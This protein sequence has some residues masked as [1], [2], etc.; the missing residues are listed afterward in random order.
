MSKADVLLVTD[1]V[2]HVKDLSNA[3]KFDHDKAKKILDVLSM[4]P[5]DLSKSNPEHLFMS[6][7][8]WT[9]PLI[10]IG[11]QYLGCC[12][13]M[14]FSHIHS[15]MLELSSKANCKEKFEEHKASYLEQ[16]VVEIL[17]QKFPT[18]QIWE[19]LKW[20]ID[21]TEYETDVLLQIDQ[22]IFIVEAKSA[23]ITPQALRGAP[24]RAQRHVNELIVSPANQSSRL[25]QIIETARDGEIKSQTITKCLAIEPTKVA[26]IVR[27]SVTLYDLSCISSLEQEL[28]KSGWVPNDLVLPAT[29]N[30]A[31]FGCVSDIVENAIQFAHYFLEREAIQKNHIIADE[32]DFLGM[33]L[34][35]GFNAAAMRD[36]KIN[37]VMT[38]M[39]ST[40]D[41]Y[42]NSRD[43]GIAVT[44]PRL[45]IHAQLREILDEIE[46]KSIDGWTTMGIELLRIGDYK[47]QKQIFSALEK[48]KKR[49]PKNFRDPEHIN[50]IVV[51]PPAHRKFAYVFHVYLER[52]KHKRKDA[53]ETM[54][55]N[56]MV[57]QGR[58]RCV[59][60]GKKVE[61]WKLPYSIIGMAIDPK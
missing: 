23:A 43:A 16:K 34:A 58:D 52:N 54:T 18:A 26:N 31:D 12:V 10:K 22:T 38:G 44:K 7:P 37:L 60:V 55:A 25:Q 11:E 33:Y 42:Y 19:N 36:P 27:I 40:V 51:T 57:E 17:R 20:S 13:Q 3:I 47:E 9:K 29:L 2:F 14:A 61:E 1:A 6:N 5:G 53:I 46:R 45:K 28:K 50:S 32:L 39:S 21:G 59:F 4:E 41:H 15:L 24:K 30:I 49:V 8:V 35:T 56:A 48:L